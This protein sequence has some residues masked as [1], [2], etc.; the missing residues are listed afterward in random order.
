MRAVR[1]I[2]RQAEGQERERS[3]IG[4]GS[5]DAELERLSKRVSPMAHVVHA[6]AR[7]LAPPIRD[8]NQMGFRY[9]SPDHRHFCL[10][11]A[12]RV[13]SALRALIVLARESFPQEIGVLSRTVNEFTR[14]MEAVSAQL[15]KDG[16]LSGDLKDFIAAYFTDNKRGLGPQKRALLSEKYLNELLGSALDEF[17]DRSAPDW[18][19]AASKLHNISYVHANYVHGRYPETMDL[20][21]GRPGR[22]HLNGMRNTPKDLENLQ[23]IDALITSASLCFIHLVHG[24]DL[25][26]LLSG[27]PMLVEWYRSRGGG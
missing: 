21:G 15:Q 25:K 7:S 2:G 24:L 17:S 10:M 9:V 22:F 16:H 12:A 5:L 27:N 14:Q 13:V 6:F 19:S 18:A 26:P 1:H 8:Q 11:R 3:M 23:M 20:Y 4:T